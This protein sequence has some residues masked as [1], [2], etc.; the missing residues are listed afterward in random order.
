MK[1]AVRERL[2]VTV[3][4]F[5]LKRDILM[6]S[7]LLIVA[8]QVLTLFLLM[9][10]GFFL[11]KKDKFSDKTQ[12]QITFLLLYLVA[13]SLV[14]DS[15]QI[16]R[17]DEILRTAGGAA[18]ACVIFFAIAVIVALVVFPKKPPDTRDV[19][20]FG[21]IYS[22]VGF[23][24]FP[25]IR[26]ILGEDA[27]VYATVFLVIFQLFHW[28]HGVIIMGGRKNA[29][30]KKAILN[31][32]MFGF[33]VGT[34]MFL[35]NLRLPWP[36][37]NAVSFIS[38]LNTPLAMLLI[39]A[40]MAD[41]DILK[42][43]KLPH[44]YAGSF[45]KLIVVPALTAAAIYPL[46]LNPLVYCSVVILSAAPSAG[47]TSIFAERYKRDTITAAQLVTL[48]TLL[49]IITLPVFAAAAQW[50]AG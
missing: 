7:S 41:A 2:R 6:F 49:S 45:A 18:V 9:G 38:S 39:G 29:S 43:L 3:Y 27:M 14:I 44:L 17:S 40:I 8:G 11:R 20:R 4:A 25:L 16:E 26:A 19:L 32:G 33:A 34:L 36:V 48:S 5:T 50:L 15:M 35:L 24:G 13:P 42:L 21:S 30:L 12:E 22:N 47:V 28:T 1:F 10:T 37:A 31:P 23:M 46:H